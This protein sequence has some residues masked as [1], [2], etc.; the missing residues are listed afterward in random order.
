MEPVQPEDTKNFA[1]VVNASSVEEFKSKEKKPATDM[2]AR[3]SF[4]KTGSSKKQNKKMN[5]NVA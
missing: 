5:V 4:Q 1:E 2:P 3:H